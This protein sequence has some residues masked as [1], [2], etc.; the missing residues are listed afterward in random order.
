VYVYV[1]IAALAFVVA[2]G[3]GAAVVLM[4]RGDTSPLAE[5]EPPAPEQQGGAQQGRE[6][7]DT[8]EGRNADANGSQ[9]DE[10]ASQLSEADYV[11]EVGGL[12]GEA[13][14][15]F[16]DSHDKFLRYDAL[17]SDDIAEMKAD[18]ATLQGFTD[19]VNGLDTPQKYREQYRVFRLG[20]NELHEAAQLAYT[21]A[22][23]PTA[24]TQSGF[25]EYDRHVNQA[26][27]SL[28]KSNEMLDRDYKTIE[29]A[30]RVISL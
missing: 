29:G 15:T 23:D 19:Q 17:T 11:S 13:V 6:Q 9:Q 2:A 27:S 28:K 25:Y 24:A 8:P 21:L 5:Q 7:G 10:G 22:A 3:A 30:R 26:A 4:W 16:L 20:I 12:Q 18:Q 14:E 1:L